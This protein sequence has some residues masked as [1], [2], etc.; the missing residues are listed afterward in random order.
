MVVRFGLSSESRNRSDRSDK[1]NENGGF[2]QIADIGW[3]SD[4]PMSIACLL[5]WAS[6]PILTR[7]FLGFWKRIE[8]G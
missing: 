2:S 7:A 5:C 3:R 6:V 4:Y 1:I 8:V